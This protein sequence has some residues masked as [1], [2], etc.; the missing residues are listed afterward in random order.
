VARAPG[1]RPVLSTALK[2]VLGHRQVVIVAS[3][4]AIRGFI[5]TGKQRVLLG[6]ALFLRL[7]ISDNGEFSFRPEGFNTKE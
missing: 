5:F 6:L 7:G 2:W 1:V 3:N 4:I